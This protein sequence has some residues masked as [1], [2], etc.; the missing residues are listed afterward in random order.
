MTGQ[1]GEGESVKKLRFG[2]VGDRKLQGC[3]GIRQRS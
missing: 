2:S 1:T 3:K